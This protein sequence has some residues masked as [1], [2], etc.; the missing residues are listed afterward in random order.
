MEND[1]A[2]LESLV[3]TQDV[4]FLTCE[5]GD[6]RKKK[7]RGRL[8]EA[9]DYFKYFGQRGRLFEGRLFFEEIQ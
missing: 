1:D 5:E 6:K 9:G 3:A 7:A 8:F 2:R 4:N